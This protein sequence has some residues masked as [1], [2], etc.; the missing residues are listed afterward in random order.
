MLCHQSTVHVSPQGEV[1]RLSS[2]NDVGIE[3]IHGGQMCGCGQGW[4]RGLTAQG[5]HRL[6][7]MKGMTN[8]LSLSVERI[9]NHVDSASGK[10]SLVR[11]C[12]C[13]RVRRHET[14]CS[15]S[16]STRGEC[17]LLLKELPHLTF[18][19]GPHG[20]RPGPHCIRRRS[21]YMA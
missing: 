11:V 3:T 6:A 10:K 7:R 20:V 14:L 8:L 21:P 1:D 12:A 18:N 16:V 9:E 5:R 4:H 17:L 15:W 2:T 13:V 19:T